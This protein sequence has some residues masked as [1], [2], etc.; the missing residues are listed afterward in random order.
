M[1][2]NPTEILSLGF[3]LADRMP[4]G[5]MNGVLAT[6]VASRK[7]RLDKG[8]DFMRG[9]LPEPPG[10]KSLFFTELPEGLNRFVFVVKLGAP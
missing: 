2:M 1:P 8:R 5:R 9:R 7:R 4:D 6:A 3:T 10:L